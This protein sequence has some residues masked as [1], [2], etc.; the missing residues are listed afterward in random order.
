[1]LHLRGYS[2]IQVRAERRAS[3]SLGSRSVACAQAGPA[4]SAALRIE[5]TRMATIFTK[6]LLFEYPRLPTLIM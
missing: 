1:V 6:A 2:G 3:E 5:V 4:G